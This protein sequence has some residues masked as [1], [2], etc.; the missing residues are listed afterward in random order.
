MHVVYLSSVEGFNTKRKR[1]PFPAPIESVGIHGY[2]FMRG[3]VTWLTA[4]G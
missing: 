1:E 2:V 4:V 3:D